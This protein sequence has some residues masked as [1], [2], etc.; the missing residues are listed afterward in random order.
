MRT[1]IKIIIKSILREQQETLKTLVL[2]LGNKLSKLEE[3][4]SD[5]EK[6]FLLLQSIETQYKSVSEHL[7]RFEEEHKNNAYIDNELIPFLIMLF[8]VF[9]RK[10]KECYNDFFNENFNLNNNLEYT[11]ALKYIREESKKFNAPKP[12]PKRKKKKTNQIPGIN[13]KPKPPGF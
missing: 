6:T 2:I 7:I 8:D 9:C 13:K 10:N 5:W 4:T 3:N 11:K 12:E 1:D